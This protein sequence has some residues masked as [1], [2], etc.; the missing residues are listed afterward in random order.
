M[1]VDADP[2]AS[3]RTGIASLFGLS[4]FYLLKQATD[5]FGASAELNVFT[6][7][8]SL[9][10]EEQFYL[11]FPFLVWFTKFSRLKAKGTI[12]LIRVV[13]ALSV[14]SLIAFVYLNHTDQPAAYFLMPARLWELG[15]PGGSYSDRR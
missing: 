5:Y 15:G 8:W 3:L 4:N 2:A 9:G 11:L 7:T 12:N 13:G 14:P 1:Q 10:V 6:H